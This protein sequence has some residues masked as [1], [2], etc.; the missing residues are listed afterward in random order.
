LYNYFYNFDLII[1]YFIAVMQKRKMSNGVSST[2]V[3][4]FYD[5]CDPKF[6]NIKN[7]KPIKQKTRKPTCRNF[8][9]FYTPVHCYYRSVPIVIF[10][11]EQIQH[12]LFTDQ[13]PL[14]IFTDQF[15]VVIIT[16]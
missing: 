15:A 8:S 14:F 11:D 6:K 10:T 1:I 16:D 4:G 3:L 12:R 7:K 2:L 5:F 9:V 13:L